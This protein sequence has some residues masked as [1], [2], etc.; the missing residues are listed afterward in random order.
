MATPTTKFAHGFDGQG[1]DPAIAKSDVFPTK[2]ALDAE[3]AVGD[4]MVGGAGDLDDL[5][6]LNVEFEGCSQHRSTS[7]RFG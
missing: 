6:V 5:V 1:T 2:A 7:K 4:L 3:H